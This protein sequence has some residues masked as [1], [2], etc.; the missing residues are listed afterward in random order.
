MRTQGYDQ[1]ITKRKPQWLRPA[2]LGA[3][4]QGIAKS[5]L[6]ALEEH[7]G[8]FMGFMREWAAVLL[9]AYLQQTVLALRAFGKYNLALAGVVLFSFATAPDWSGTFTALLVLLLVFVIRDAYIHGREPY[10]TD[11]ITDAAMALVFLLAH[12]ALTLQWAPALAAPRDVFFKGAVACL[13]LLTMFRMLSRPLPQPDPDTPL[14][15][16]MPPERIYWR[17]VRLNV[18]WIFMFYFSICMFA[19][20]GPSL[21]DDVR[22]YAPV[23][24]F[25]T[26]IAAQTNRLERR[27]FIQQL[28]TVPRRQCLSR[29]VETLPQGMKKGD[30]LYW[31]YVGLEGLIFLMGAGNIG[32]E[33]WWWLHG[34]STAGW[35]RIGASLVAFVVT[36]V[37]WRYVKAANRAA[38]AQ[39]RAGMDRLP[40]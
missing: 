19:A 28:F 3:L 24:A 38:V 34:E 20:D 14:W 9:Q 29:M 12:E 6:D 27:N 10:R 25:G 4:P 30:P 32:V 1:L 21:I 39:I 16:G 33:L 2:L 13:P 7:S 40:V 5:R 37:S 36:V 18:L 8:T 17:M 11:G 23:M 15:P 31:W 35:T 26:W 22:G